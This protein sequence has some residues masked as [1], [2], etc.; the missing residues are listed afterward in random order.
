MQEL[1]RVFST[2]NFS[3]LI[4]HLLVQM[5]FSDNKGFLFGIKTENYKRA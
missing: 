2:W 1:S 4:K 5:L 3:E